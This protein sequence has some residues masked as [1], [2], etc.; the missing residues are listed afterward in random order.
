MQVEL[1]TGGNSVQATFSIATIHTAP[2]EFCGNVD[3][4]VTFDPTVETS[5]ILEHLRLRVSGDSGLADILGHGESAEGLGVT[6]TSEW[7][8]D[9]QRLPESIEVVW[10]ETGERVLGRLDLE[11]AEDGSDSNAS[12]GFESTGSGCSASL[13]MF[14][15]LCGISS[16]SVWTLL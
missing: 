15:V 13:A 6:F 10:I 7:V 5:V 2:D 3:F 14:L 12:D 9:N 1:T 8:S 4:N 16:L 11:Q